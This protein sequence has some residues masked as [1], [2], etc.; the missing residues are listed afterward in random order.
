MAKNPKTATLIIPGRR[1][2]APAATTR[3][4]APAPG[5][6]KTVTDL[7]GAVQVVDGF[8]LSAPARAQTT[9]PAKIEVPENDILEIEVEGGFTLWTSVGRYKDDMEVLKPELVEGD[10]VKVDALPQPSV[11]ERG[12]RDWLAS[13]LSI[14]RLTK[15]SIQE[16]LEDPTQWPLD[17]VQ[18]FGIRKVSELGAWL[19]SKLIIRFIEDKLQPGP[20]LYRWSDNSTDRPLDLKQATGAAFDGVD[21]DQ[22]ILVFI[23]GTAS[24]TAGSYGAFMTDEAT[25]VWRNLR[26][27]FKGHIYAFEHRTMSE[28]PIENAIQLARGLPR[29]ASLYLVS[30]S[31]GGLVGDLLCLKSIA[32]THLKRFHRDDPELVDAD[33]YDRKKIGELAELL[34]AKKF[35]V[36]RFV[37]C[38]SPARGTLLASENIDQFLSVLTNL[39]GLIPG[40]VGNPLY[41]VV[42]RT[43]LEIVKNRTEPALIP[44]IEAMIPSS[45]LVAFLNVAEEEAGGALGVVAGDIEGGGWLKRLGVFLTDKFIYES[46]DNDLVVNTDSMFYGATRKEPTYYVFDQGADVNH[47]NYFKNE[48]TRAALA[49]WLMAPAGSR[50]PSE[51]HEI[52]G[53]TLHPVPMLRSIQTRSGAAQPIVFV[54][55]GIMG[56]H[57]KVRADQVWLNYLTLASGGLG[58]L[59]DIDSKDVQPMALIGDYYR[60]L[61]E[62]LADTHEVIPFAYDWRKSI[63]DSA[64]LLA[65]EVEKTLARTKEPV[66]ILAHSMGGLVTRRMIKARPDLWDAVCAREGGRFVMLGTPNRGSQTIVEAL[67][68][69]ATTIQHL[70]L[71]DLSHNTKQVVGI[72]SGFPGVLELLPRE[73]RF[74]VQKTWNDL[75]K[76][77]KNGSSPSANILTAANATMSELPLELPHSDRVLYVA[78]ASLRTVKD[79]E[80]RNGKIVLQATTEGDGR[81]T[82]ESGRLPGV[83]TWYMEAEHGDLANHE[84]AFPAIVELLERG[85]TSKLATTPPSAARGGAATYETLPEPVLYP[86]EADLTDGLLG[87]RR[88]R[89]YRPRAKAGFRVSVVHGDLRFARFPIVVGHYQGDTIIGA[90]AQVDRMLNGALLRRYNLGLYPGVFGSVSV[91]MQPPTEMQ[92]ALGLPHGAVIIGLGKWGDLTAAQLANLIRQ[93]ALEYVLQLRDQREAVS[94][95]PSAALGLSML[96]VGGNSSAN[97]STEDSVAAILRGIAQANRE[98]EQHEVGPVTIGEIEIVE[99]YEDTAIEAA[100]ATR[101]LAEMI[102]K[103]LQVGIEALPLLQRGKYGRSRLMPVGGRE[104]WRRWEISVVRPPETAQ[105]PQLAKPLAEKLKRAIVQAG[106]A[107]KAD[108]ELITALADLAL[109][110]SFAAREPHRELRFITLSDRARAEVVAQQRQPEL[111]ERLI[112]ASVSKTAYRDSEARALF[113]LMIPNDL[114]DGL[115]QLSRVVLVVD[116]ETSEYPWELMH[117]GTGPLCARIGMVRQLQTPRFRSHIRATTTNAAFVVGDPIVSPPYPQLSGARGEAR[118]VAS[119]LRGGGFDVNYRDEQLSALEVLGGLFQRPYRIVHLAGHGQYQPPTSP[120]GKARSG[121]VLDNGVFLTAV[122]IGQM[123]Q[124]PE[125]VFLNCCFIGQVGPESPG[126]ITDI[127]FN[128]LAASV[129]RELIEMGVRAIV[130]AG[131]AV[132]DDAALHFAKRFY[133]E[134][135]AGATFGNALQTARHDTWM[136]PGF[137]DCNTWGAYQAHGDPD[138]RLDPSG[139]ALGK[140]PAK[141]TYVSHAE[142]VDELGVIA[143]SANEARK[144]S[145]DADQV[146]AAD[147]D[148]IEALLKDC[149]PEWL[150]RSEVLLAFGTAYGELDDF[151]PA[152]RYLRAALEQE[153]T[154]NATTLRAVEQL[155]NFEARGAERRKSEAEAR[156]A[157]ERLENLLK[158]GPSSER[159]SLL[160][161]AYKRLATLQQDPKAVSDSIRKAAQS[162]RA[163]H[164][165]ALERGNF[166]PYP[167]LNW[168]TLSTI[169][170]DAVPEAESILTRAETAARERFAKSRDFFDASAIPDAK[171]AVALASGSLSDQVV[172]LAALYVD[173]FKVAS[174]TPREIDSVTRQLALTASLMRK[175]STGK[176]ADRRTKTADALDV[177]ADTISG[178][179]AAAVQQ[180]GGGSRASRKPAKKPVTAPAPGSTRETAS[181]TPVRKSTK[182]GRSNISS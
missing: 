80:I 118:E 151:D 53:D 161:G 48:R 6:A 155:A 50:P 171:V 82:Y 105:R 153:A 134:M 39:I 21:P 18:E 40:L 14:L 32:A 143:R 156:K 115:A 137:R 17:F 62:R 34:A 146:R 91:A 166:D 127:Q 158:V 93:A 88:P 9:E 99:L 57:L 4:V 1:E 136:E 149:P 165:R 42:K 90:E 178:R 96:L 168:M 92:R 176:T 81:V 36:Q 56:S 65:V 83:A 175:L 47:F 26:D 41:E 60:R 78:G 104:P 152:A 87:R 38:A 86:Q 30:H 19:A 144:E 89:P 135:L 141:P 2:A 97:I 20:G 131:W 164:Q 46:R 54:L 15:D 122:E 74:F 95:S 113:E 173:A 121:M 12:F 133:D 140:R 150:D 101:R 64:K 145:K 68:G 163:A 11:S 33:E 111:I 84:E 117:D 170:G 3:G 49:H 67:L 85:T 76:A 51:F 154:D 108:A 94:T 147:R 120:G 100:H 35:R 177:L 61:C 73:E 110:E 45:P 77:C 55:P 106:T 182:K 7:L 29:N 102:H 124:V 169:A 142:L 139:A 22:P 10:S 180:D 172:E 52:V 107:D 162:Y 25:P 8:S 5:D 112:S 58:L 59:A 72:I 126:N 71:L 167:A 128:R 174:A 138:F 43:T 160:G 37:R 23:H 109:A 103:E 130:A 63:D 159:Y 157:I 27:F 129:S 28:S 16:K 125:L 70:A 148:R 132:R 31:R 114:K 24:N 69:I 119:R 98:I 123:Q 66:R 116:E 13:R 181:K 75:A 179:M 79:F 44:G